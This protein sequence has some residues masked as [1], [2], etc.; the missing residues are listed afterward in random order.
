MTI[1]MVTNNYT[2][3]SGGVVS[4]INATVAVLRQQ[5]HLVYIATFDFGTQEKDP[6]YVYRLYCPFKFTYRTHLALAWRAQTQLEALILQLKPDV[7]H[8]HHPFLLGVVAQKVAQKHAIP[9]IFTHHTLYEQYVHYIPLPALFVKSAVKLLVKRYCKRV[10]GIIVPS[11]YVST[12]LTKNKIQKPIMILPSTI[13]SLF[14]SKKCIPKK[15]FKNR[16]ITLLTVSRFTPEKNIPF[17]IDMFAYLE[18]GRFNL[19]I[20]GFGVLESSLRHYAYK[21]KKFSA[22]EIIFIVKPS[23]EVLAQLY[24]DA[25][26]FVFA[27]K[28]ETQGLVVNEALAA[29]TP[30]IAVNGSG[31]NEAIKNGS[32]GFLIATPA[33]M[34]E[35]IVWISEHEKQWYKLQKNAFHSVKNLSEK[36]FY[37]KL[38]D[39]YKRV[40]FHF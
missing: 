17:L 39:F 20:V 27:S 18:K 14:C 22:D 4:S 7:I 9:L 10:Q 21:V 30:V 37:T 32:N 25:D 35:K 36:D 28:T 19:I 38:L 11:S 29:G 3:Y 33:E 5:G 15:S 34:A 1:L 16:K 6:D 12:V 31:V 8:S 24:K 40:S 23:K 13:L 2:P 26:F